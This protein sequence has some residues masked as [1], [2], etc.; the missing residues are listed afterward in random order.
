MLLLSIV[1]EG[2]GWPSGGWQAGVDGGRGGGWAG[3]SRSGTCG[4]AVAQEAG[5]G[6]SVGVLLLEGSLGVLGVGSAVVQVRGGAEGGGHLSG[7]H[8]AGL[9]VGLGVDILLGQPVTDTHTGGGKNKSN[10]GF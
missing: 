6:G 4:V 9:D 2:R 7:H 8:Q 5:R 10:G 3:H 1:K